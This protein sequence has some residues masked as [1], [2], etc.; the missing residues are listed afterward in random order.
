MTRRKHADVMIAF[1]NDSSLIV[2]FRNPEY[3][4]SP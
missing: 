4:D 2:E 1:A 3:A